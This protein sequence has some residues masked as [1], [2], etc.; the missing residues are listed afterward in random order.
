MEWYRIALDHVPPAQDF[1]LRRK[2]PRSCM[3]PSDSN[4]DRGPLAGSEKPPLDGMNHDFSG[5][6]TVI[7]VY[8]D[9]IINILF[10]FLIVFVSDSFF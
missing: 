5:I 10:S 4:A 8:F 1:R 9:N 2:A 6:K 7:I 3:G